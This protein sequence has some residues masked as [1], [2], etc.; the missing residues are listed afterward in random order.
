MKIPSHPSK[1]TSFASFN[2]RTPMATSYGYPTQVDQYDQY[3]EAGHFTLHGLH[4]FY[5]HVFEAY[6]W[7][8]LAK[9][10]GRLMD[11]AHYGGKLNLLLQLLEQAKE[12][13]QEA[14]RVHDLD[15][16]LHN[17]GVLKRNFDL[18]L[19]ATAVAQHPL[20]GFV[21][22]VQFPTQPYYAQP[23][24]PLVAAPLSALYGRLQGLARSVPS[25]HGPGMGGA[26]AVTEEGCPLEPG[27]A[28]YGEAAGY[29][30]TYPDHSALGRIWEDIGG[31]GLWWQA[32]DAYGGWMVSFR[33]HR[34]RITSPGQRAPRIK[35]GRF[36]SELP[37]DLPRRD[38]R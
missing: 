13:Y 10:E 31:K 28:G 9:H 12:T 36:W 15:V 22:T 20:R 24:T 2:A 25:H 30:S 11:L 27:Y 17:V 38:T 23:A 4:K 6:G 33:G 29:P 7:K 1:T 14:D 3:Q 16:M 26:G 34:A 8:V 35:R 19:A 32:R 21:P 18:D 37:G 5:N